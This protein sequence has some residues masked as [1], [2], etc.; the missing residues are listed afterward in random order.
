MNL[1]IALIGYGRMGKTIEQI[2]I[3]KGYEVVLIID[4]DNA[5]DLTL[6][7]LKK[8][9]VAIE[10]TQPASAYH[11]IM[12]CIKAGTPVIS[13]TTGWLEH[14]DEVVEACATHKSAF[15]YA[16]NFSI[17]V[18]IFFEINEYL[19]K[20]MGEWSQ[21]EP[22]L[23]EIH[24]IHKLDA[25]SGTGITLAESVLKHLTHKKDWVN[26]TSETPEELTLT[27]ERIALTP[28]THSTKY[29]STVDSIEIIHTAHSRLGFAKGAVMA[30]EW[31]IGK[32]GVYNM[33]QLLGF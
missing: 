22:S 20:M 27:S 30:A 14:Y 3:D 15:F 5:N 16:S 12:M 13:G 32:T 18:N 29:D 2:A 10:F 24:H 8:A 7:N 19:A 17:G 25:P 1:R 6:E 31:I 21:Y 28:G 9:D 4:K 11:N 33:R 26:R 23:N